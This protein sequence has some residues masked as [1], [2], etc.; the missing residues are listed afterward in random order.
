MNL[1][2]RTETKRKGIIQSEKKHENIKQNELE[3]TA[4]ANALQP[5]G[6]PTS[7]QLLWAGFG[8]ICTAYAHKL[9][10]PTFQSKL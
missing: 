9:Q 5:E 8:Q 4:I 1:L 3:S 2:T 7:H 10:F 6:F